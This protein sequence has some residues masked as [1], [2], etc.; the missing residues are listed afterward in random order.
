MPRA[1][2]S[3]WMRAVWASS[4]VQPVVVELRLR[5]VAGRAGVR[6]QDEHRGP[7]D[8]EGVEDPADR[9][10]D[11]QAGVVQHQRAER[12][13]PHPVRAGRAAPSARRAGRGGSRRGRAPSW[14]PEVRHV[15]EDPVR[16]QLVA[17]AGNLADPPRDGGGGDAGQVEGH[18]TAPRRCSSPA[19]RSVAA[20]TTSAA[21]CWTL[22]G[23]MRDGRTVDPD[24]ADDRPV[25][26]LA[27]RGRDA[28]D[29]LVVLLVVE[30]EALLPDLAE[31]GDEGVLLRDGPAGAGRQGAGNGRQPVRE[32]H[33]ARRGAVQRD[34]TT[35]ARDDAQRLA[36]LGVVDDQRRRPHRD[37]GV[38]A[39]ADDVDE[40]LEVRPRLQAQAPLRVVQAVGRLDGRPQAEPPAVRARRHGVAR[41]DQRLQ[42]AGRAALVDVEGDGHLLDRHALGPADRIGV[43]LHQEVQD[44]ESAFE[45]AQRGHGE[46]YNAGPRRG[47]V[48]RSATPM[49]L[50][51]AGRRG[52]ATT[53]EYVTHVT[54]CADREGPL[55]P[56]SD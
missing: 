12:A 50:R 9:A 37:G 49:S 21:S 54:P 8:L 33:L 19:D 27:H 6:G 29:A 30:G 47:N 10:V 52:R 15:G 5:V 31:L 43:D 35:R 18:A 11:V 42:Q 36:G 7:D 53:G 17:P 2:A 46:R 38:R 24:A 51:C 20:C 48:A 45:A 26:P 34:A 39:L 28:P 1:A 13:R 25:A 32:Q 4:V 55:W 16:R 22:S 56:P 23:V 40:V 14:P 44:P 3:A 41:R